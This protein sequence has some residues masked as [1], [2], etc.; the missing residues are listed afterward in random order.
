MKPVTLFCIRCLAFGISMLVSVYAC[1]A[2]FL[3]KS[4]ARMT[5][6]PGFEIYVSILKS[7][8][9]TTK[10]KLIIGDS[11][12]NQF[13]NNRKDDDDEYYSLTS[14]QAISMC[15]QYLL[16]NNFL[17]AGNRPEEVYVV[18]CPLAFNNNLDQI[19]TYHYFLKPFYR[20]EY[21]SLMTENVMRQIKQIPYYQ[22]SQFPL[23]ISSAWAPDYS[24]EINPDTFLSPISIDY[25]EKMDTLQTEYGFKL[26][27][28]SSLVSACWEEK[29]SNYDLD[30]VT[31]SRTKKALEL[32]LHNMHFLPDSLF[33]D[34]V[35]LLHPLE[36]KDVI[37]NN[38][39]ELKEITDRQS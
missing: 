3:Y 14:N 10:K 24:P 11:T 22:F 32:Y 12:A 27:L 2:L 16:L 23:L 4:K 25:L 34:R 38:M 30:G 5:S 9:K 7:K 21:K 35:H 29:A 1:D 6:L 19:F 31:N 18:Y 8:K 13:F 37:L 33:S 39:K 17:K 15:G 26:Y 28:V 20:N 36:Y